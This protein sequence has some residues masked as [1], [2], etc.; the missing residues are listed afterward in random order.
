MEGDNA[1]PAPSSVRYKNLEKLSQVSFQAC[2]A[3][4]NGSTVALCA[5]LCICSLRYPNTGVFPPWSPQ[6]LPPDY[7]HEQTLKMSSWDTKYRATAAL[8][9]CFALPNFDDREQLVVTPRKVTKSNDIC[10]CLPPSP[11]RECAITTTI[12]AF[13]RRLPLLLYSTAFP[14][15]FEKSVS[16][17][18]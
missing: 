3:A 6:P 1:L 11:N 16:Y 10:D 4:K 15:T 7:G 13:L 5:L 14:K 12:F 2:L 18:L 8:C 17:H 9:F